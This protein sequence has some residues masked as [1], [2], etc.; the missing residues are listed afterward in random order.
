[1]QLN[2]MRLTLSNVVIKD[3]LIMNNKLSTILFTVAVFSSGMIIMSFLSFE[4]DQAV[5]VQAVTQQNN[6]AEEVLL[7][8]SLSED[9]INTKQLPPGKKALEQAVAPD[10]SESSDPSQ[11]STATP[12]ETE[13]EIPTSLDNA[14]IG[15]LYIT[16]ADPEYTAQTDFTKIM[17][18]PEY[19]QLSRAGRKEFLAELLRRVNNNELDVSQMQGKEIS[20]NNLA[21]R[22]LLSSVGKDDGNLGQ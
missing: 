22:N 4:P 7:N 16:L 17:S 5:N 6:Q 9:S 15:Q 8:S 3:E 1:M 13:P 20:M 2:C 21:E 18:L 19:R 10:E 14:I 11:Q 12:I